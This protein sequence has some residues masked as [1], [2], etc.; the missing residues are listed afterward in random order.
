M[1]IAILTALPPKIK[2]EKDISHSKTKL[3]QVYASK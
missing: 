3:A 1:N 2:M